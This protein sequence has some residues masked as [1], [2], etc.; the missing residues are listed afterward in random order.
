MKHKAKEESRL[1]VRIPAHLVGPWR[2]VWDKSLEDIS[3]EQ[4]IVMEKVRSAAVWERII[5]LLDDRSGPMGS[6]AHEA[7]RSRVTR[8]VLGEIDTKVDLILR[9]VKA[10]PDAA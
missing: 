2:E 5:A 6:Y 10:E 9:A 3:Y 8:E 1:I 7:R 4:N